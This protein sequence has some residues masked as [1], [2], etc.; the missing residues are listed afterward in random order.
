[1]QSLPACRISYPSVNPANSGPVAMA[2][3]G[4]STTELTMIAEFLE[5]AAEEFSEHSANDFLVPATAE[6]KAIFVAVLD[7]HDENEPDDEHELTGAEIMAA[8]DE[9]FIYDDWAMAYFEQRCKSILNAPG[10][11]PLSPSELYAVSLLLI[12]AHEVHLDASDSVCYD[13]SYPATAD[14]RAIVSTTVALIASEMDTY[15]NPYR[16]QVR[17]TMQQVRQS[18]SESSEEID[19]PDFWL[20][21]YLSERCKQL[22]GISDSPD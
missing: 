8:A 3:K 11:L 21:Q 16:Q 20:M 17:E 15:P 7:H 9:V 2:T 14:N 12:Y 13:L 19:V 4:L 5:E 1:M 18:L 22:S 10:T 6:N